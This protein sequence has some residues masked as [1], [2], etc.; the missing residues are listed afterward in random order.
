M[1]KAPMGA[2]S[3]KGAVKKTKVFLFIFSSSLYK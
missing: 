1:K 2:F 3:F